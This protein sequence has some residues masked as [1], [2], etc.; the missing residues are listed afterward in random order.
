MTGTGVTII[1]NTRHR[2]MNTSPI[3][4]EVI[5]LNLHPLLSWVNEKT[6]RHSIP[7]RS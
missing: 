6:V 3:V 4:L 1:T 5:I 2:V 7:C